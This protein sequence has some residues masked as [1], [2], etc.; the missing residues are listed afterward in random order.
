MQALTCLVYL[1]ILGVISFPVGRLFARLKV[2]P[3]TF[4]FKAFA[5]EK[6]GKIYEKLRI[7][8]WKDRVPDVSKM[9]PKLVPEKKM[10]M[11]TKED[12]DVLINETCVAEFV[13]LFLLICGI[14]IPFIWE[15]IWSWIVFILYEIPGNLMFIIIQRY[16]RFRL[17]RVRGKMK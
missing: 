6:G 8:S 7:K 13:H 10:V 12:I 15:S 5:F 17:I 11:P 4:P 9:F 14:A 16:N 2:N 3:E 1:I